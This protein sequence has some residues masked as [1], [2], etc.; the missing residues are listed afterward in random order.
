MHSIEASILVNAPV[1]DC[2][3][4]WCEFE[5]FPEFMPRVLSVRKVGL[6]ELTHEQLDVST[7]NLQRDYEEA[8][9]AQVAQQVE[10][11]GGE[12]W[13]WEVKG[14]MGRIFSWNAGIVLNMPNKVVTWASAHDQE[15]PTTGSVNFLKQPGDTQTLIEVKMSFS[16]PLPP[17][18]ELLADIT[19]YGDNL[20]NECL[21][22]F[23]RYM[24]RETHDTLNPALR[25]KP[26][27]MN[28]E[29]DLREAAGTPDVRRS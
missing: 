9:S 11:H 29:K 25:E 12:V 23:K 14:P 21:A 20:L 13:H 7:G 3:R 2:Y 19:H 28:E 15:L 24:E 17:F 26:Q 16:A 10:A 18:G 8:I 22:D 4:R 5:R 6:S 27:V 1:A